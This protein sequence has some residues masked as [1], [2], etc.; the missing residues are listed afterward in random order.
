M[1]WE[2]VM[3]KTATHYAELARDPAWKAYA[4]A[5]V[6]EME[7]DQGGHWVG[8]LELVRKKLAEGGK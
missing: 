3:H 5:R 2:E 4:K 7:A 1:N 8:L 6:Q